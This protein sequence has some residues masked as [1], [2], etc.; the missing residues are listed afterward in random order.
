MPPEE[1]SS[2]IN[3]EDAMRRYLQAL[4]EE[5]CAD[6]E[7]RNAVV[8]GSHTLIQLVISQDPFPYKHQVQVI[9]AALLSHP[10]LV[11]TLAQ[12]GS[13][14][15]LLLGLMDAPPGT[16]WD[17]QAYAWCSIV[18]AAVRGGLPM[19]FFTNHNNSQLRRLLRHMSC[20]PVSTLV[21]FLANSSRGYVL[22]ARPTLDA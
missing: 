5:V 6:P 16:I 4:C 8:S 14:M 3:R 7:E 20:P 19:A 12:G 13:H 11:P 10:M 2:S 22:E 17:V 21:T 15:E 18:Q 9:A 1:E